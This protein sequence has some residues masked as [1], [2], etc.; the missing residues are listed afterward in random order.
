LAVLERLDF[1]GEVYLRPL[2][3]P[4]ACSETKRNLNYKLGSDRGRAS[5]SEEAS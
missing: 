2:W 3:K 4:Y 1:N 5:V